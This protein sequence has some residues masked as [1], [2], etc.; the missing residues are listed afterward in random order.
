M[1]SSQ[2]G[3]V[4]G[5][6]QRAWSRAWSRGHDSKL[7]ARSPQ[8]NIVTKYFPRYIVR[9]MKKKLPLRFSKKARSLLGKVNGL[10]FNINL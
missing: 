9:G 7:A 2:A 10:W 1:L 5:M 8:L 6:E 3:G 4:W